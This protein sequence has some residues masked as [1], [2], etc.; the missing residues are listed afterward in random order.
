[1]N[2]LRENK[3]SREFF[4][5]YGEI[6]NKRFDD[7]QLAEEYLSVVINTLKDKKS[8]LKMPTIK[9]GK[10]EN[11]IYSQLDS[12]IFNESVKSLEQ[13]LRNKRSL[14]KHLTR[15]ENPLKI[16]EAVSTSILSSLV[17]SKFN[18]KYESL[19]EEEKKDLKKY[20]GINKKALQE[21]FTTSKKEVMGKLQEL[22][23]SNT[24]KEV[25]NK[26][27]SVIGQIR[28]TKS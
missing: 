8:T 20:M 18:K 24:D 16:N 17:S 15:P 4:I 21:E 10:K 9:E 23:E 7:T 25:L 27:D 26:L 14:V 2:G 13:N 5:L 22:K 1:M 12:L 6:E 11:K 3:T 28:Y 19:S